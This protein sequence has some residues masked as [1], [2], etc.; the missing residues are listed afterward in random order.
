M[1]PRIQEYAR[2][3]V[4]RSIDPQPGWQ[5]F[6]GSSPLARPL[7]E[8]VVRLLARRGAYPLVRLSYAL[9][10]LPFIQLWAEQAPEELVAKTAPADQ[11]TWDTIDAWLYI[12]AP[13]NTREGS[14]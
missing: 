10:Q 7:V 6:V 12:G 9:E 14:D 5:V 8:E 13:E 3:L 11:H 1:D 4:E 2:L